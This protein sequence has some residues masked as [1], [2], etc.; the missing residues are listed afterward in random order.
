MK[1][2]FSTYLTQALNEK[3][4]KKKVNVFDTDEASKT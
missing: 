4:E 2:D 1:Y 3:D